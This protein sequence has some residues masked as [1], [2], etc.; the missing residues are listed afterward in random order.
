MG[1]PGGILFG[2]EK[3]RKWRHGLHCLETAERWDGKAVFHRDRVSV[4]R[5]D[6]VL[7]VGG[8]KG[9]MTL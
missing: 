7:E 1:S 2:L 5:D 3:G 4:C 6:H 8:G 9:Y